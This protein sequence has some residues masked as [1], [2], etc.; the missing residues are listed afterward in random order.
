VT[1]HVYIGNY[2]HHCVSNIRELINFWRKAEHMKHIIEVLTLWPC[3]TEQALLENCVFCEYSVWNTSTVCFK[4]PIPFSISIFLFLINLPEMMSL[5][6]TKQTHTNTNTH[7]TN[8]QTHQ[9]GRISPS[10]RPITTQET[11]QETNIHA[12]YETR[13]CGTYSPETS[14]SMATWTGDCLFTAY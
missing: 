12:L 3:C 4:T 5:D 9:H 13:N 2:I 7:K 11:T 6:H 1:I 8:T 14:Y 10:Q